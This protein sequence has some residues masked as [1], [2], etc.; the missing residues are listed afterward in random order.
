MSLSSSPLDDSGLASSVFSGVIDGV[1]D[2]DG[3]SDGVGVGFELADIF[4][5]EVVI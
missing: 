2:G 1:G 5:N 4:E 3:D